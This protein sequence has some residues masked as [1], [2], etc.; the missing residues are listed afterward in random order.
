MPELIGAIERRMATEQLL[1][2]LVPLDTVV[3]AQRD[4]ELRR[5]LDRADFLLSDGMPVVWASRLLGDAL[6]ERIAGPDLFRHLMRVCAGR[7]YSVF[8]LG[9]EE[10]V[11]TAARRQA[12]AEQVPVAGHYCPPRRVQLDGEEAERMIEAVNRARPDFLFVVLGAPKQETWSAAHLGRLQARVVVPIGAAFNVYAGHLRRAPAWMQR[13]GL[14]WLG[15]LLQEP[16]LWRRYAR[17]AV[18]AVRFLPR[19]VG[20]RRRARR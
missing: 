9:S 20:R 11:V 19:L 5:A 17:D 2:C 14:E 16:R 4:A 7:R 12:E 6:P 1:V 10:H 8:Y 18:F 3:L 15:R 13:L